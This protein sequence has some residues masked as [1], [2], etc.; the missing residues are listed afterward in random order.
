MVMTRGGLV[1]IGSISDLLRDVIAPLEGTRI[2]RQEIDANKLVVLYILPRL[3]PG[4]QFSGMEMRQIRTRS[5]RRDW[6][7]ADTCSYET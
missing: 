3:S 2:G 5:P 1:T 7:T 4:G 6:S